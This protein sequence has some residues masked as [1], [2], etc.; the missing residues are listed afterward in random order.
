MKTFFKKLEYRFLVE[1]IEK[2]EKIENAPFPYKTFISEA[3]VKTNKKVT[4]KWTHHKERSFANNFFIFLEI[5][6]QFKNLLKYRVDLLYRLPKCP[7]L[8]FLWALE[9]N[10]TVLFPCEYP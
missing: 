9:F 1:S 3:N 5:L 2:I 8:Y 10:L 4:S 6:F 7:Y